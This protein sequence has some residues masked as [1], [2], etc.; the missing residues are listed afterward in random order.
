M[1]SFIRCY[2]ANKFQLDIIHLA[3]MWCGKSVK[4][5][6]TQGSGVRT[7]MNHEND[8]VTD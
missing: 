5:L 8:T 4:C 3:F 1:T 2:M 6:P 7:F